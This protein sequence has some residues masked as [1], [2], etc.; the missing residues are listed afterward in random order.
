MDRQ[1]NPRPEKFA[2]AGATTDVDVPSRRP[3]AAVPRT[4]AARP[5]ERRREGPAASERH[6]GARRR[7]GQG[8][9]TERI[10]MALGRGT[11]PHENG[12]GPDC[13]VA[14]VWPPIFRATPHGGGD[15]PS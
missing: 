14:L 8:A 6:P 3:G 15:R 13:V 10:V 9:G 4:A 11:R 2:L 1:P 7:G 5:D 12:R